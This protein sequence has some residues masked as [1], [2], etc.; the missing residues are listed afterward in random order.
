VAVPIYLPNNS[1]PG[2]FVKLTE[3]QT[4]EENNQG[5]NENKFQK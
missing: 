4:Q 2:I 1:L 3:I 5:I